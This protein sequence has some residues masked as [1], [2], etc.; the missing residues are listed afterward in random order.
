[1]HMI[2]IARQATS[3]QPDFGTMALLQV[4]S[5]CQALVE[6]IFPELGPSLP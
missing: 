3:D 4:N 2:P 5:W 6:V 1:M